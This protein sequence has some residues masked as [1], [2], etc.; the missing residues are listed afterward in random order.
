MQLQRGV[1]IRVII[2]LMYLRCR[3]F[4]GLKIAFLLGDNKRHS[5]CLEAK[6]GNSLF[7]AEEGD[8]RNLDINF[9]E[10]ISQSSFLCFH[11]LLI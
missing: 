5:A 2:V 9:H 4:T 3:I 1:F 10:D 6:I 8:P 7:S 11:V